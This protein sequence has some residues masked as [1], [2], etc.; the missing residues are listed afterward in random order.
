MKCSGSA[1]ECYFDEVARA[2]EG[3]RGDGYG[4]GPDGWGMGN[5]SSD[6]C[7][8]EFGFGNSTERDIVDDALLLETFK[9][10]L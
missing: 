2:Y 5:G 1:G 10:A 9:A 4:D 8:N 6:M 3:S 7:D